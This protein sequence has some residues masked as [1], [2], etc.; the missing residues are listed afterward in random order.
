ME[1]P[2]AVDT[3]QPIETRVLQLKDH[4]YSG[5]INYYYD[6]AKRDHAPEVVKFLKALRQQNIDRHQQPVLATFKSK[7]ASSDLIFERFYSEQLAR[8]IVDVAQDS[9]LLV[10]AEAHG[11][12]YPYEKTEVQAPMKSESSFRRILNRIIPKRKRN[13]APSTQSGV[14]DDKPKY[15]FKLKIDLDFDEKSHQ[16]DFQKSTSSYHWLDHTISLV[17]PDTK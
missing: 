12:I 6:D 14:N 5:G 7:R 2:F 8:A 3:E 9:D 15:D 16:P 13:I 4:R 1:N 11:R 10:Q 17:Y